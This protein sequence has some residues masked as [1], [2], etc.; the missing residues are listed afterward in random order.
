MN[1]SVQKEFEPAHRATD[2]NPRYE[3]VLSSRTKLQE[4][5]RKFRMPENPQEIDPYAAYTLRDLEELEDMADRQSVNAL[6][7]VV[8]VGDPGEVTSA[9]S[10][11]PLQK[12]DVIIADSK[13]AVRVV[14]WERSI[15]LLEMGKTYNL[16]NI[17]VRSYNGN[18]YLSCSESSE[19]AGAPDYG[20]VQDRS[21]VEETS[22]IDQIITGEIISVMFVDQYACCVACKSKVE[23]VDDV[24][25]R[26][27]KC[28]AMIQL[29]RCASGTTAR[30][31]FES[32]ASGEQYTPVAF[33]EVVQAFLQWSSLHD[34][35]CEDSEKLLFTPEVTFTL[36]K[37][38]VKSVEV[39]VL[40]EKDQSP[41]IIPDV[42][43]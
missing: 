2:G 24:V 27:K 39:Q 3:V 14:L 37:D 6:G 35:E 4:S 5:P 22:S 11:Q 23:A 38:V 29:S 30:F 41:I 18:K 26:C 32:T 7:K 10:S 9:S 33:N 19:C 13:A 8:D 43:N 16:R 21:A 20:E 34:D 1:C 17:A 36:K 25:G 28:S 15:G 12:Q 42:D 40:E 31:I